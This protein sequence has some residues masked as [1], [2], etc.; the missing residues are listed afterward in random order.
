MKAPDKIYVREFA[1][2]LSQM[3]S[4]IRATETSAIAQHEYIRKEAL[5]KWLEECK[6]N[7]V[8]TDLQ[9]G[10]INELIDKINLM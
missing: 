2:G 7:P 1:G 5:L 4:G 9:K 10:N 8:I 6:N 3:W